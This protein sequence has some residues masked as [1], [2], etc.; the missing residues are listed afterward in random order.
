MEPYAKQN[1]TKCLTTFFFL[2]NLLF[3]MDP[4]VFAELTIIKP[5]G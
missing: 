5:I 2:W 3:H 4:G 1:P